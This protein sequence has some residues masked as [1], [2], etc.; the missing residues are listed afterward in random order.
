[1]NY[2]SPR[3]PGLGAHI[4]SGTCANEV[5]LGIMIAAF[6]TV[7]RP[8]S[9]CPY[10]AVERSTA[11]TNLLALLARERGPGGAGKMQL[12]ELERGDVAEQIKKRDKD[13]GPGP[14]FV[15]KPLCDI[16]FFGVG[17][18]QTSLVV[19]KRAQSGASP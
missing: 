9:P 18:D 5:A 16:E 11:E 17:A 6:C 4:R 1:V 12:G 8:P 10:V 19:S 14:L 7:S 2:G 13:S 3:L 15:W